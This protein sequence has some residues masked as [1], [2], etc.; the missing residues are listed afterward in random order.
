MVKKLGGRDGLKSAW[1]FKTSAFRLFKLDTKELLGQCF[2]NDWGHI[3]FKV[4]YLIK[5]EQERE[6]VRLILK[7]NYKYIRD[8]Y[9]YTAGL[10]PVG[11][12]MSIGGNSF[13]E[14][15]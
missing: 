15:M 13:K 12:L 6:K 2:D 11:N 7:E 8:A 1:V 14:L 4:E 3:E 9:K 5:D 10:D